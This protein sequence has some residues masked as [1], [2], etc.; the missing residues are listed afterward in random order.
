MQNH[1]NQQVV[2]RCAACAL[3]QYLNRFYGKKATSHLSFIRRMVENLAA[4]QQPLQHHRELLKS[5]HPLSQGPSIQ[6]SSNMALD[7]STERSFEFCW[8]TWLETAG[9][10]ILQS[11]ET[12]SAIYGY[13][14][15]NKSAWVRPPRFPE[16][17]SCL[18]MSD[19]P[20][21]SLRVLTHEEN[22]L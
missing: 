8:W 16:A 6:P 12:I 19:R 1:N 18:P 13:F 3:L 9:G 4:R 21:A 17:S 5:V 2:H 20:A 14:I 15:N 7:A 10:Q 22:K 11:S